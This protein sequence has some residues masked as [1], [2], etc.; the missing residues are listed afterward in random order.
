MA[1]E[2]QVIL[3]VFLYFIG[4]IIAYVI[5][6]YNI[7]RK[8]SGQWTQKDRLQVLFYSTM[9]LSA[10]ILEVGAYL[11]NSFDGSKPAKW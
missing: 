6:K 10:V 11:Y 5:T 7:L 9:S 4:C 8:R 2:S 1:E 3:L